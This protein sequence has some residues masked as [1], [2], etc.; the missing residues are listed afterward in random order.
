VDEWFGFGIRF[1]RTPNK[2]MPRLSPPSNVRA[3]GIPPAVFHNS[4]G[5]AVELHRVD[6]AS[7]CRCFKQG[8]EEAVSGVLNMCADRPWFKKLQSC[9]IER[10]LPDTLY[11]F[12]EKK[13][14]IGRYKSVVVETSSVCNVRCVWCV[15]YYFNKKD[16][17][18][19]S[20][21]N[22]KKL[23]D[24][25]SGYL[26]RQGI[27]IIPF[28]RGEALIHP[29]FF[30]LIDY[31]SA[32]GVRFEGIDTNLNMAL[33]IKRLMESVLPFVI[34]NIGG[35]TKEVHQNVMRGSDFDLVKKNLKEMFNLNK[36]NKPIYL[37]MNPAK[38]NVHQIGELPSFFKELGGDPNNI[39]IGVTGFSLPAE[40]SREDID[41]FFRNVVSK[42][43]NGYLNFTY[44]DNKNIVAKV[45]N[46]CFSVPTVKWD[47]K[48][49][50]CCHD[51]YSRL[52]LGNAF[53]EPL[54]NIL[55]SREFR[56]AEK[57]GQNRE[58]YFCKNC[59]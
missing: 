12:L 43:V 31:G 25:N 16:M 15:M 26:K 6:S 1:L 54:R 59:N 42:E 32:K 4:A 9:I 58:F 55:N 14:G 23:I 5:K 13:L 20:F 29:D 57:K 39:I 21:E 56:I 40:A 33:D 24:L 35:T 10:R 27:T 44:D 45:Q 17:G 22:F 18:L 53:E 51:Q 28:H 46:C 11:Y 3:G 2:K 8:C 49:T 37:K 36:F 48:V 7:F 52:N 34:V 47:G 30:K 19:M 41:E 38:D 50:V